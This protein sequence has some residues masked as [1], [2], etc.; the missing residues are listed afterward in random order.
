MKSLLDILAENKIELKSSSGGRSVGHCPFHEG[1]H[2][3]S[4]TVYPTETYYCFGCG[5]WGDAIKFLI[6]FKGMSY[7][8]ARAYAG[9]KVDHTRRSGIIK[10]K[11][12]FETWKLL[13]GVSE[14]YHKFLLKNP[15]ALNYLHR[16]GLT[17]DTIKNFMV[18]YTDGYVL[19][20]QSVQ[21]VALATQ[22]GL[23]N[24]AG[25]EIMSHRITF[26]NI[27]SG[28]LMVDFMTGRTVV[29]SPKKYMHLKGS[30]PIMG[31]T[32]VQGSPVLFLVEGQFDW[33]TLRQWG[34]PAV[35]SG[36][37]Y[38]SRANINAI[39]DK[40]IV[41]VP[42]YDTNDVGIKAAEAT[43][44]KLDNGKTYILDYSSLRKDGGKLDIS[45]LAE[46]VGAEKEFAEIIKEQLP[47]LG[48]LSSRT[49]ESY[50]PNLVNMTHFQ[51]TWKPQV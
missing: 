46:R 50:F 36:G 37:T 33:L 19:N 3:P 44:D 14:A 10:V 20:L 23:I 45:T 25:Q 17:I 41:I 35:V 31:L 9:D 2:T 28:S 43:R 48:N 15:G 39:K 16:R 47:W 6:E 29:N 38:I 18:G 34:Y 30:K 32:Q 51:S 27:L 21:D 42:D 13:W 24:D 22:V 49:I 11:H 12:V 4:F 40:T 7:D 5:A 26:P 8:E 1:D